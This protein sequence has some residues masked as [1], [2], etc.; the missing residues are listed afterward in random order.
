MET[1]VNGVVGALQGIRDRPDSSPFL[2]QIKCP[3]LII[4]G[5]DDQLISYHKAVLMKKQLPDSRLVILPEAGHLPNLEQP[6]RFN[7][8]VRDYILSLAQD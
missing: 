5:A 2:P 8:A 1:S 3:A 7:Q 6:E 4:H